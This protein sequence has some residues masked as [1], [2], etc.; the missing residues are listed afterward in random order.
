MES[1]GDVH[2]CNWCAKE[3]GVNEG[4]HPYAN[5]QLWGKDR[6]QPFTAQSSSSQTGDVDMHGL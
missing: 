1:G 6:F 4:R 3:W 5:A 2:F